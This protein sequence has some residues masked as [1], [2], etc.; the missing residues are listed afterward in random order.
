[1]DIDRRRLLG[2]LPAVALLA[3][4]IPAAAVTT[5]LIVACD[6]TLGP[7]LRA[8]GAAFTRQ[9]GVRIRVFPAAPGLLL[10]QLAREVQNDILVTRRE[11]LDAAAQAGLTGSGA[12]AGAWRNRLVLAGAGIADDAALGRT[13]AVTDPSPAFDLDGVAILARA[14]IRPATL[15][16]VFDTDSVVA[17]VASGAADAGLL[18]LTDVKAD[19]KLRVIR[20]IPDDAYTPMIYGAAVTILARRPDP[21]AFLRFLAT[22][23]ALG[24]LTQAG[25]EP[26]T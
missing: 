16:G 9:S 24:V 26:V 12:G 3:A 23:D 11:R 19:T 20:P 15:L 10:P 5:D 21:A 14:A 4:G 17:L 2:A 25:L 18:Y 6:T 7:A 8:V 1:M 22:S 13:V